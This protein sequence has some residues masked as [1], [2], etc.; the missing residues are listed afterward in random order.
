MSQ[1]ADVAPDVVKRI[2]KSLASGYCNKPAIAFGTTPDARLG[3]ILN[4][5]RAETR[6]G[7]L[8]GLRGEDPEFADDVRKKIFTFADIATRVKPLDVATCLRSVDN[9]DLTRAIAAALNGQA[10][11]AKAAEFILR[12]MSQRMS[13]QLRE[14]AME[15]DNINAEDGEAAM[16]A[17]SSAIRQLEQD[18]AISFLED[19]PNDT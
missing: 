18:D 5:S 13:D 11:E 8:D 19:T 15:L 2:G 12:N 16:T 3:A 4:T 14:S 6:D 9:D 10:A 1:T 7:V 17:I